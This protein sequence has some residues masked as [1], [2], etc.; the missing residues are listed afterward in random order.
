MTTLT[1][2][3]QTIPILVLAAVAATPARAQDKPLAAINVGTLRIASQ[4]DVWVAQQRGIFARNGLEAKLVPFNNGGEAI[5]AMQGGAVDVALSIPGIGMLAIER[6]FD[7]V[8][9]FQD[10]IAR[11]HRPSSASVQVLDGSGIRSLADLKGRRIAVGG[12]NTQ[13]TISVRMLLDKAGVDPKAV[14]FV[15]TPFPAML[16]ALK[17]GHVD[18]VNPV[19]PFTTQIRLSGG[20]VLSYNYVDSIP[21]QPLGVWFSKGSFVRGRPAIID[22]FI[23]SIKEAMDYLNADE[24]RAR[25][26]IAAYTKLDAALVADM[27]LIGWDY[28]VRPDKWQAVVDMMVAYGGMQPRKAEDYLSPQ[29][30]PFIAR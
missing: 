16:N 21:E 17:A 26:E 11:N 23:R 4:T 18:A 7:L 6:G 8:A 2:L 30:A 27:P 1:R 19:D 28:R 12:L 9:I 10:E 29:I 5:S 22:A 15:E 13:N 20:R 3:L 24:K 25:E 14:S